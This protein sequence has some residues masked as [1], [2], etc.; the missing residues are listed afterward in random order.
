MGKGLLGL[1]GSQ[2]SQ[3]KEERKRVNNMKG[4]HG[5]GFESNWRGI[6]EG[7]ESL[8]SLERAHKGLGEEL[9]LEGFS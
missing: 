9:G 4:G 5:A 7:L 8:K 1:F 2:L 6:G 3:C